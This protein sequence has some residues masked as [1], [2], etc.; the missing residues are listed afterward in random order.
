[1]FVCLR[2]KKILPFNHIIEALSFVERKTVYPLLLLPAWIDDGKMEAKKKIQFETRPPIR[3]YLFSD[4]TSSELESR[5]VTLV[6]RNYSSLHVMSAEIR[7]CMLE[8]K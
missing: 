8:E 6:P 5:N 1:M 2:N 7:A 3:R 4:R